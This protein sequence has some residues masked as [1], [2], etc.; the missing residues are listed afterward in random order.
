MGYCPYECLICKSIKDNGWGSGR[1]SICD[2]CFDELKELH[3]KIYKKCIICDIDGDGY[4]E[5]IFNDEH[6]NICKDCF[7]N[8]K[9]DY[10]KR[11]T[12]KICVICGIADNYDLF[13]KEH[14]N[15]CDGCF[16]KAKKI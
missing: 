16:A 11:N 14:D 9:K 5:Y 13:D 10:A 4:S 12:A 6:N 1:D 8:A 7:N 2:E 3:K 15:I